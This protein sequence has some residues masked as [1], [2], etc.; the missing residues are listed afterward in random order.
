MHCYEATH[1][2]MPPAAVTDAQGHPLYS[3][4]VLIL[5]Y[6]DE[7]E[8]YKQFHLDE[9]WNSPHNL[10]LFEKMPKTYK[11]SFWSGDEPGMTRFQVIVGPGTAF[12][13]DGMDL[14]DLAK[15]GWKT[16]LIVQSDTPVPWTK[17]EEL[18]YDPN[19]PLPALML[20]SKPVRFLGRELWRKHGYLVSFVDAEVKFIRDKT[21]ESTIRSL[22]TRGGNSTIDIAGLE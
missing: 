12:E 18:T 20:Q 21:P 16:I 9:P 8:L 17:P 15:G 11:S 22:I 10:T 19:H 5:P 1:D 6:I 2:Q 13:R 7:E 4:R 14:V 3:W